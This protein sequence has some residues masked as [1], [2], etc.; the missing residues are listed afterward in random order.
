MVGHRPR[1][2]AGVAILVLVLVAA[3]CSGGSDG[4]EGGGGGTEVAAPASFEVSLTEFAIAP[5]VIHAP[6]ARDLTF[7]VTNDG[8]APHTFAVDTG[9]GVEATRELQ[10]GDTQTLEVPGL[11]A[12]TYRIFCT[13]AG[14]EDLGMSGSLMTMAGGEVAAGGS[15]STGVSGATGTSGSHAGMSVQEMLDGHKAGVEAFPAETEALGNQPLEPVIEG[16]VKVFELTAE[17]LQWETSPGVFVDAMGFNGTVPGPEIRVNPGDRVRIVLRNEM[18]QPTTLHFHG[19][20][21]PNGMDGVPYITQD[22]ILPG[23]FFTYEF[24]IVDPPGMYVYH[25]H[26]NSTEQVGKGLYGAFYV[27]PEGADWASVYGEPVDVESTLFLGDGPTGYVLNGKGFPATQPIVAALGETV[28]IHLANDGAMIHP[29]HLHGYHFEVVAVD[30]FVL[31]PASRYMADT[32]MIAP[33]QRFDVLVHADYPGVWA[34]HCHI[35]PHVE[36]PQGMYGMVTALVV[37]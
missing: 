34:Y 21:V 36:G 15:G 5:D 2:A 32:L 18:S 20:T 6:A 33:G 4:G 22:P 13:I 24:E 9:N 30:G 17:E 10:A 16:G 37:Q 19:L 27:E 31:R 8:S 11:A 23:G 28:L 14:H 35:L 7:H 3:A 12:G 29:M 25:S 26:F 1:V